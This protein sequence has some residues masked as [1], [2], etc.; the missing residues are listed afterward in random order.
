MLLSVSLTRWERVYL[1]RHM[2]DN[3]YRDPSSLL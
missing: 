1:A 3:P 2:L